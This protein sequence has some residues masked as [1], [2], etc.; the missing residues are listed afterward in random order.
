MK[1]EE[2]LGKLVSYETVS[3]RSNENLAD[4]IIKFLQNQGISA[5]KIRGEKG[6][7]NIY[8]R[9]GPD[10][11]GGIILSGHTDVVPTTGQKWLTNPFKLKSTY[12]IIL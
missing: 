4:F 7:F 5:K 1:I 2:I 10:I 8:S 6:R 9:I 3:E 12:V 11:N